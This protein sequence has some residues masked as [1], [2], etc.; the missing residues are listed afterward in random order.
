M[1]ATAAGAAPRAERTLRIVFVSGAGRGGSLRSTRELAGRLA[2]RGHSVTVVAPHDPPPGWLRGYQR[3]VNAWV[4]GRQRGLPLMGAYGRALRVAGR[5][6]VR[7]A[8]AGGARCTRAALPVN[9]ALPLLRDADVVIASSLYR[10]PW[11]WLLEAGRARGVPTV[12]Y[13]REDYSVGH[14][15]TGAAR[16]DLVLAN[17]QALAEA[18]QAVGAHAEVIPSVVERDAATVASTRRVALLVN[19]HPDHGLDLVVALA[20]RCPAI[21]FVLQESWSMDDAARG[22]LRTRIEPL[23]NV[24]LRPPVADPAAVLRDA[25]VLLAPYGSGRPRVVAEAQHN[26]IP[27]LARGYPAMVEAVGPGGVILPEDADV[28]RWAGAL[29]ALWTDAAA[30]DDLCRLATE[31]DERAD[32]APAALAQR[33]EATLLTLVAERR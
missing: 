31:H 30:Y 21:P 5:R 4:K 17:S 16:P 15:A 18:A 29:E 12:L 14:L 10:A 25:R 8:D 19:P 22:A 23:V 28:A 26:G 1:V 24:E 20:A 3:F 6:R 27:V 2:E 7:D 11:T 9:A 32:V 33:V 13:L